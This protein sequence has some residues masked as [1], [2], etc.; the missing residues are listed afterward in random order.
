MIKTYTRQQFIQKVIIDNETLGKFYMFAGEGYV[1][2]KHP[3]TIYQEF[4]NLTEFLNMRQVH[5]DNGL[6]VVSC[7][8][9]DKRLVGV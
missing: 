7:V 5:I 1:P 6:N 2:K 3:F 8:G 9:W 4:N